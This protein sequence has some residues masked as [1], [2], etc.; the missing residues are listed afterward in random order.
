[1]E[2]TQEFRAN[3]R[4]GLWSCWPRC[5]T[6]C[7]NSRCVR[8]R[9]VR[10]LRPGSFQDSE[11]TRGY[12]SPVV[13]PFPTQQAG[14]IVKWSTEW[15]KVQI[16]TT[17]GG[18]GKMDS[19]PGASSDYQS[20][21]RVR[22]KRRESLFRLWSYL[23]Q[24]STPKPYC[25]QVKNSWGDSMVV[26]WLRIGLP[27]CRKLGS[28]PSRETK[29]PHVIGQLSL[30]ATTTEAHVLQSPGTTTRP[31]T[32]T[33]EPQDTMKILQL[34]PQTAKWMKKFYTDKKLLSL[35]KIKG[36]L[37]MDKELNFNRRKPSNKK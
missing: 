8:F 35:Y 9:A 13:A 6:S 32:A 11:G 17:Y 15:Q 12:R 2:P 1:M 19:T 18:K 36:L 16:C 33:K 30:H 14:G 20:S 7:R 27:Q 29:I 34:R 22:G 3:S 25:R 23:W 21:L 31:S 5:E 28:I 10:S 37:E 24:V 4:A 26:Q